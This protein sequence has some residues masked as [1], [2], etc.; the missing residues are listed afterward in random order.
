MRVM[1]KWALGGAV[2]GG[3]ALLLS[4]ALGGVGGTTTLSLVGSEG[5]AGGTASVT[6]ALSNDADAA[7]SAGVDIV[8]D[9]TDLIFTEPV[10]SSCQ[11][12]DRLSA[13]HQLGGR[14]L[15]T[16][17]LIVEIAVL[18]TPDPIP[19]L[20]NGDLATCSFAIRG[21]AMEGDMFPVGATNVFIGDA[22]AGEVP[23][24]SVDG[25]VSV[26]TASPTESPT[27][28][29]TVAPT[30]TPMPGCSDDRDCP[31]GMACTDGMCAEVTCEDDS[32]C[33][34]GSTCQEGTCGPV[35]CSDDSD[36]PPGSTCPELSE[37]AQLSGVGVDGQ[38]EPV[39][40]SEGG[41]C[42]D[43]STCDGNDECRPQFCDG[44]DDCDG[45]DI[46]LSDG[47]CSAS[48]S[49]DSQCSD[50]VCEG[51]T[52]VDCREDGDC[53]EGETCVSNT[54]EGGS[55]VTYSM[56]VNAPATGVAGGT[57]AVEVVL[58]SDPADQPA[59]SAAL[60]LAVA[61]GLSLA[62]CTA[63]AEVS[64]IQGVPGSTA[65]ITVGD[66]DDSVA[67]GSIVTC[68]V[69]IAAD[70]SGELAIDCSDATVNGA[71]VD[72]TSA[73]INVESAV[74]TPTPTST[75]TIPPTATP[76]WTPVP[77]DTPLPVTSGD[78]DGCAVGPVS[79]NASPFGNMLLLLVP[80]ILLRARRRR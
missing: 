56:A 78:D 41:E 3:L 75:P 6:L 31:T 80:A 73:T 40:C 55:D 30:P 33:P 76:T 66:G 22:S 58:S 68:R 42:P 5:V 27:E 69:A 71:A 10:T 14:V 52:C 74:P 8:F 61:Q 21:D 11:L 18:G 35:E 7:A 48:C 16:G 1:I 19:L 60:N 64:D 62:A 54:C 34:T 44:N 17:E 53:D 45:D 39:D 72:C 65:N 9:D 25:V 12:D 57:A 13:T 77:T 23:S 70:A 50:G 24:E 4:P 47:I 37:P 32:V 15:P 59:D 79:D 63:A 38:C 67:T 51:E 36:C 46:C 43:R 26:G 49:D 2:V 28:S 29:P 20:G